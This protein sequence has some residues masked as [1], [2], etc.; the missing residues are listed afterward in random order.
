MKRNII[1]I[2]VII[3]ALPLSAQKAQIKA[4][5]DYH[6]FDPRGIEKHHDF[7]FLIISPL[8]QWGVISEYDKTYHTV[9]IY[10]LSFCCLL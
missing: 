9:S 4:S 5:Y 6:F 7:F 8:S 10:R 2:L 3:F 1:I